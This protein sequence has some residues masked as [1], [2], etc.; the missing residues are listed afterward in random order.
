MNRI[1][2]NFQKKD[3]LFKKVKS[4]YSTRGIAP[5][6]PRILKSKDCILYFSESIVT[7]RQH[8]FLTGKRT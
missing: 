7:V 6:T 5:M 2:L 1:E 8:P 3:K 4:T